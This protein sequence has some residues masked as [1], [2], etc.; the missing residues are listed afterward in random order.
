MDITLEQV[1]ELRSKADVSW[2][3]AKEV[4]ERTGGNVLDALILLE[5]EGDLSQQG[6]P[7][8]SHDEQPAPAPVSLD[9][10]EAPKQP[11]A[12]GTVVHGETPPH[13]DTVIPDG[14]PSD[15]WRSVPNSGT[16]P[17]E[18]SQPPEP[19]T[20]FRPV[21]PE[22]SNYAQTNTPGWLLPLCIFVALVLFFFVLLGFLAD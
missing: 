2:S 15:H 9:K 21:P 12:D 13:A 7:G 6:R 1:E 20:L 16:V 18:P 3:R 22:A 14:P 19:N 8:P 10:P 17:P 4:L 11:D 5:K